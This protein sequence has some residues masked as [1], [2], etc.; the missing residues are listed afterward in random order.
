MKN[1]LFGAIII[2]LS[3]TNAIAQPPTEEKRKSNERL[4]VRIGFVATPSD[5]ENTFGNGLDLALHWVQ[6]IRPQFSLDV[7]LGVFLMGETPGVDIQSPPGAQVFPPNDVNIRIATVTV[8]PMLD[9]RLNPKTDFYVS[10]G[11]GLYTIT[12]LLGSGF[13][14]GETSDNHVGL[15][16]GAGVLRRVSTNWYLDL[17]VQVHKFWTG[18]KFDDLFF[19]ASEGD[20]DP[21]FYQITVGFLLQLF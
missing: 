10:G 6:R 3:V 13:F 17:N 12:A 20:E 21:L 4:G 5:L 2:S 9:F 8:A 11:V 16:G 18:R 1:L 14:Q 15:N 7:T 19:I